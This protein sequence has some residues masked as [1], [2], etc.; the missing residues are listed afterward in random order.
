MH[1]AP[2]FAATRRSL[3]PGLFFWRGQLDRLFSLSPVQAE[4]DDESGHVSGMFFCAG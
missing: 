2:D 4:T 3:M 1:C